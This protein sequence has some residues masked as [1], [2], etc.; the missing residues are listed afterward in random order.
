MYLFGSG[1]LI[2]TPSGTNQTPINFGLIQELTYDEAATTKPLYGQ[3]RRALAIGAGTIKA[4]GKAKMAKISGLAIGAL[5]YGVTP[6]T[7]QTATAFNEAGTIPS[8]PAYTVTVANSATYTNDQG[9]VYAAS[10]L[11]LKRVASAPTVGQ[12]S[13]VSGVYT[14]SST[15][16]GKA[17]LLS[18]NYTLAASGT[19]IAISNPLLGPVINFGINFVGTDPTT[20]LTMSLQLYNCVANKLH[21]ATKLEDFVMPE[22]DF[23]CYAG[24]SG[25]YGQF[26][27]PDAA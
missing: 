16:A 11:P 26:N 23:E 21:F 3:G 27:F 9:V 20:N 18:Y 2:G 17:V 1:A 15:D 7:G 14:F 6:V 12:Y 10:G 22:I 5:F 19:S 25:A 4:T 24:A 13:V 8:V